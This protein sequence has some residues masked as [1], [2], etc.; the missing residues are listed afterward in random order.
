[1][2]TRNQY[3]DPDSDNQ[4]ESSDH[5]SGSAEDTEFVRVGKSNGAS[6][7][8][9]R[10]KLHTWS[11]D[12]GSEKDLT[13]DE[14]SQ[15]EVPNVNDVDS[16]L[17]PSAL[18]AV[19]YPPKATTTS[20]LTT[21]NTTTPT[22]SNPPSLS[23]NPSNPPIH[24]R[25]GVIYLSRIPPFMRPSTVR[26]LLS[27]HGSITRLF[28]T[29]EP[30]S[31]YLGRRAR[32]GNKKKS[33][34]DGWVEFAA[35]REARIC[36]AAINAQT[37]GRKAGFYSNDVWNA[38]Y[39]KGFSWTDLM[40]GARAEER[41]R[42]ERVRVGLGREMRERKAFL[43]GVEKGRREVAKREK[44]EMKRKEKEKEKAVAVPPAGDEGTGTNSAG[45]TTTA[46]DPPPK[47]IANNTTP[48]TST[49]KPELRFR[50]HPTIIRK[51]PTETETETTRILRQIF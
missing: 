41:E 21:T 49:S 7:N 3:L 33:Y 35:R 51:T 44:R 9:K 29:P 48:S 5:D 14:K 30:P 31:S 45:A 18:T 11:E 20:N 46:T 17:P 32:G 34:I 4:D 13:V 10:R 36:A 37:I 25:G 28:L 26:S 39:L 16:P 6:S 38:R 43:D 42:E 24:P 47:T 50:Q 15:E 8:S 23:I 2:R 1:M 19:S 12:S 22:N 40:A 27:Q